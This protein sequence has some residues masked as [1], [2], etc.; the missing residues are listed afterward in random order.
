[1]ATT[2]RGIA[3]AMEIVE[4][5]DP[6]AEIIRAVKTGETT[7]EGAIKDAYALG[8]IDGKAEAAN[9]DQTRE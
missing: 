5:P 8:V 3:R 1:M 4:K 6:L 9:A 2:Q 7:L